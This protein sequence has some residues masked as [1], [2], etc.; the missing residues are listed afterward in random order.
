MREKALIGDDGSQVGRKRSRRPCG[1]TSKG[2]SLCLFELNFRI[3]G[4]T[5]RAESLDWYDA[6]DSK[7]VVRPYQEMDVGPVSPSSTIKDVSNRVQ[8]WNVGPEHRKERETFRGCFGK[9]TPFLRL[10]IQLK[11]G[12]EAE[13]QKQRIFSQC[14]N[15]LLRSLSFAQ[16][17]RLSWITSDEKK[18]NK[19]LRLSH[20]TPHWMH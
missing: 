14:E 3:R 4:R 5:L 7:W 10:R 8:K 9:R 6:R 15:I 19:P 1:L 18:V 13:R 11:A 16:F 17:I 2:L 12:C 20:V